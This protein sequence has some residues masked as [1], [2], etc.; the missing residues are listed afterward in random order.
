MTEHN[1]TFYVYYQ[2]QEADLSGPPLAQGSS[3]SNIYDPM[4]ELRADFKESTVD[5]TGTFPQAAPVDAL[6]LGYTNASQFKIVLRSQLGDIIHNGAYHGIGGRI[7]IEDMPQTRYAKSFT[8]RLEGASPIYLGLLY[9]GP[10]L[11][12]PRFGTGPEQGLEFTGEGGRFYGGQA[13]GMERISLK[14]FSAEFP[15]ITGEEKQI[16]ESYAE[17][18]HNIRPHIID[19]YP[20]ARGDFPPM[21]VTLSGDGIAFQKR[22]EQGFYFSTALSWQEAR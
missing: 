15:R 6:C 4:L 20:E 5:I 13:Y 9:L 1:R 18:V 16:M 2:N 14:N 12:L 19:P 17:E 11:G 7:S 21:Y 3:L 10:C 22:T 8:L